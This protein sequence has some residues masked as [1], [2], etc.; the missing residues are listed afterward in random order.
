MQFTIQVANSLRRSA[1]SM[2]AG[3][4]SDISMKVSIFFLRNIGIWESDDPATRRRMKILLIYTVWNTLLG[5]IT[6]L[7]DLY[8]TTLYNGVDIGWQRLVTDGSLTLELPIFNEYLTITCT[9]YS[10]FD[11]LVNL[12]DIDHQIRE[13]NTESM[14]LNQVHKFY[15]KLKKYIR[16]HQSLIAYCDKLENVYTMITLGQM[17]VFSLLICLFGYQVLL[18]EAPTT[19]RAIFVFLL[20]GSMSL[21][22]M[23]TYS[24]NGVIEHTDNIAIGA[25]SALWTVMPMNTTGKKLRNDLIMVIVR[26]RRVCC[27]TANGFFPVSLETY[28]TAKKSRKTF[29]N[30]TSKITLEEGKILPNEDGGG[31]G[32]LS[33]KVWYAESTRALVSPSAVYAPLLG[34]QASNILDVQQIGAAYLS[35][36]GFMCVLNMHVI[37]QFQILQHRLLKLWSAIEEQTDFNGYTDS[38]YTTFKICIRQHQ[39]LIKFCDKLEYVYTLPIFAHVVVFSLLMCLDAYEIILAGSLYCVGTS[40]FCFDNIFC[41]MAIHLAGQFRILR[42]RLATMCDLGCQIIEKDAESV[43][44][45]QVHEFYEKFKLY[46]R[47]HQALIDFCD[48][49]ENVYTMIILGQVLVFSILICLFGYQVLVAEAPTTRRAIFVFLLIGSMSLLFTF[50]YSCNGIIEHSDNIAIG[51]YSALWTVMPMNTTGKKLRDDLIMVIVRARRVCCLTANGFFPVSLETYTTHN[52]VLMKKVL[53]LAYI[54]GGFIQIFLITMNCNNIMDE[55]GAIGN[56]I[57]NSNWAETSYDE[58]NQFRKDMVTVM[59]R[60]KCPCKVTAAKFFPI[61]LQSFTNFVLRLTGAWITANNSEE[62]QR[63]LVVSYT[64]LINMY[65]LYLN[66]GDAYCSQGDFNLLAVQQAGAVYMCNDTFMCVLNMHVIC[67]FRI[68]QHRLLNMWSIINKKQMNS[69]DYADSYYTA[70][71]KCIQQHQSL[72]EFCDNLEYVY[73]LPIFGHVIVFVLRLTGVWITANNSEER[74]RILVASYTVLMNMYGLYL[75]LGDAYCSQG[76]FSLLAVQQAG[77]VYM[78]NDTFMC[79]L[80]MHVICQ[81]RILQHRLLN[82]WSIIDEKQMNSIDYADSYYTALKKCIQQH[83]SLIEFCDNLEHVY[84]LPI[85]GHVVVFS[86]LMCLDMYEI[87][88][89]DVPISTRL[90][91]VFHMIGSLVHILFFTYSCHGLIEESENI[92]MATYSG[93]WM[94]LPMTETGK[95][96]RRDIK[97][98]MMKSMRPCYLSA[99]GFFPVSL[100]T[101]LWLADNRNQQRYRNFA[102]I[103]TAGTLCI[104]VCIGCRDIYYTWGNFADCIF[105]SCNNLY[106]MIVVLKVSVLFAHKTEFFKLITFTQENF[107]R[108]SYDPHEQL[109]LSNCKRFCTIIIVFINICVQGTCAGYMVTPIMVNKERNETDRQLPFNLWLDFPVSLSPY[110]EILFAL[111]EGISLANRIIFTFHITGC[112]CQLLMFTYSC[113]CLIHDSMNVA[114]SAYENSWSILPMDKYGKMLRRDLIL[115][116]MRSQAPCCLTAN[117]FFSVSLETYTGAVLAMAAQ[118]KCCN[119]VMEHSD[120][121]AIGAYSALWTIMPMNRPGKKLRNDLIMVIMRSRRVC[122]LTAN[123]FFPVSL[124]TYTSYDMSFKIDDVSISLTSIFMKLV[125]LWMATNRSEQRLRHIMLIYTFAA[126]L[127]CI[128]VEIMELYHSWGDFGACLYIACNVLSIAISFFKVLILFV[129]KEDLFCSILYLKRKF[130]HADYDDYEKD[131]VMGCKQ[132]CTFFICIFTLSYNYAFISANIGKNESDRILPFNMWVNLPLSMTPY[133]EI[134]F[135]IQVLALYHLGICYFCF[136]NTLCIINLHVAGQFRVLQYRMANTTDLK[137]KEKRE[138]NDIQIVNSSFTCF[139]NECYATFKK[140]IRQHQMLIAYCAKLDEVFNLVILQQVLMF[141]LLICLDGYQI[142]V[143][144]IICQYKLLTFSL[145]IEA[146]LASGGQMPGEV[147]ARPCE[148]GAPTRTRFIF[149]FRIL[150]CLCQLLMFTYSCDCILYESTSIATAAY[151]GLW[152]LL[153]MTTSGRMMRKDLTLVIMRSDTFRKLIDWLFN[154]VLGSEPDCSKSNMKLTWPKDLSVTVATYYL[155]F[156]GFWL[157]TS[158]G[159]RLF[160]NA[161]I[162]Y[163][164]ILVTYAFSTEIMSTAVSYFTILRQT[165]MDAEEN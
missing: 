76:D 89:A 138:K 10:N 137:N 63:I 151:R 31:G 87:V 57:Y 30:E 156:S 99:G 28:S 49:L 61:S 6:I 46:V 15:E 27:L 11:R 150:M 83:Q 17:V 38:C 115:V 102:L 43:L 162:L 68:L 51:A 39:S 19:R 147:G 132:K 55:S 116:A 159:E 145:G 146:P 113:D 144:S 80:N 163:T 121:I 84:T 114:T 59:L 97:M 118:P 24:C 109:I 48:K 23:I 161:T 58:F 45:K 71:K 95:M 70:L 106:V 154:K 90:I 157:A 141:S 96:L 100:E 105:I 22:F 44:A 60:S 12:C 8:F 123:G 148:A 4:L 119:C 40:Y 72:I 104:T 3:Q 64:V 110:F 125:G 108:P 135:V 126:I 2:Q 66:L 153:P 124:E 158:R 140:H 128:W 33:F 155:K 122:C 75:N 78:C 9:D 26:A 50:T 74:Q 92:S 7:R 85:F 117:G 32:T 13:K 165:N 111:E 73:T 52:E 56:A 67:Q 107:W 69:I 5:L 127:F 14:L 54:F 47:Q 81:F 62:R 98:M 1:V 42:Y 25:Y 41:I 77:A 160:R 134:S 20:I 129:H 136:D 103:Y 29:R 36:D 142:L 18:A 82:L 16:Q 131:I 88:L 152:S 65:G 21:L 133:Y 139:V 79:V 91:F 86:L 120:N 149:S 35:N 94:V 143:V 130:L 164:A 101:C 112:M 34:P 93:W 53:F 37:C